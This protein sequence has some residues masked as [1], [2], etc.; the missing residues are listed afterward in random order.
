MKIY[1]YLD[2]SGSIHRNS[3]TKYFAIGGFFCSNKKVIYDYKKVLK[4]FKSNKDEYKSYEI[5]NR[6]KINI[7]KILDSNIDYTGIVKI[8]DKKMMHTAITNVHLYYNYAIKIL[9]IDCVLKYIEKNN[10]TLIMYID[11]R[12]LKLCEIDTLENY[13]NKEFKNIKFKIIYKDSKNNYGVQIADLIV[14]TFYNLY[15]NKK[16][17]TSVL[18]NININKYHVSVFPGFKNSYNEIK[19]VKKSKIFDK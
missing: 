17:I 16:I 7:F 14:N 1:I 2:E 6:N 11:N 12:N 10:L 3:N 15:K 8:F 9:I 13:L 19:S 18:N 4:N 5:T